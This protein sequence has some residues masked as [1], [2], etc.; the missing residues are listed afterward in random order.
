MDFQKALV[1]LFLGVLGL[2][3]SAADECIKA[4]IGGSYT[5]ALGSPKQEGDSLV[6]KHNET[7]VYQR[8]RT[9]ITGGVVDDNGSLLL[10]NL[11]SAMSGTYK[12]EHHDREGTLVKTITKK[13]CVIPKAPVPTLFSTCPLGAPALQCDP[14][15]IPGFTLSWLHNNKEIAEK[16]NPLQPKQ[17]GKKELYTCR[18]SNDQYRDD[19]EDSKPVAAICGDGKL[20]GFDKW[21]MY[22][23]LGGGG[24]L[25]LVLIILLIIFSCKSHRRRKRRQRDEEE[26][27]L[28]NL[29]Y[30]GTNPRPR[31]KQS[32]LGQPVPPTP[33][34]QDY[35]NGPEGNA[36]PGPGPGPGPAEPQPR[37]Q[38]R[39]RAPQPPT[40]EGDDDIPPLPQ[41]RRKGH[42]NPHP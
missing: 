16:N 26:L 28:A 29:R 39:P 14:K 5:I 36:D 1:F 38:A 30:I 10:N 25:L 8:R 15:N 41:P 18:L 35:L 21:I 19:K 11:T 22:A 42:R 34:E 37:R 32:A 12:A 4:F 7:V 33:D 2:A 13:L 31:P 27:R 6:W 3:A 40:E 9:T 23:I 24:F 20:F 17:R